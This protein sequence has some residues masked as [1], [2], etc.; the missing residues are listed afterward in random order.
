LQAKEDT[1]REKEEKKSA[2]KMIQPSVMSRHTR[3]VIL[4]KNFVKRLK[5]S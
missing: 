1:K 3:I 4:L 5:R 2:K